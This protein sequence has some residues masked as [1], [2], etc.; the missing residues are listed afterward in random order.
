MSGHLVSVGHLGRATSAS[1]TSVDSERSLD[2]S[3]D[4]NS[5]TLPAPIG[6][7][8][9]KRYTIRYDTTHTHRDA[10]WKRRTGDGP[11]QF[12]AYKPAPD[13]NIEGKHMRAVSEPFVF[14]WN[15]QSLDIDDQ[16]QVTKTTAH[17]TYIIV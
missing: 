5:D 10:H 11:F 1:A 7:C 8:H 15:C 9:L 2:D 4:I 3:C 14:G 13:A 12:G 16:R 6:P 17:A